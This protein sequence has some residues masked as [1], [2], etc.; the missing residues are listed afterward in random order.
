[1]LELQKQDEEIT[2][3]ISLGA[4]YRSELWRP[5]IP[6]INNDGH[7]NSFQITSLDKDDKFN[8]S[9]QN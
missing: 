1:L 8:P 4:T 2:A 5:E 7:F 3:V 6:V 9:D